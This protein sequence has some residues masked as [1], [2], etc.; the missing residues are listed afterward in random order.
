MEIVAPRDRVAEGERF[1]K[2][3]RRMEVLPEFGRPIRRIFCLF[4]EE[5]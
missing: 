4:R 1:E 2:M 3:M 5:G